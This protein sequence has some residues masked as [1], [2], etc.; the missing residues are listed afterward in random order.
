MNEENT[1]RGSESVN[2]KKNVFNTKLGFWVM[3]SEES[4]YINYVSSQKT[5]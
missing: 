2:E 4:F 1:L 3:E 5:R